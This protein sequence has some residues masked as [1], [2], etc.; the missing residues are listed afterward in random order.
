FSRIWGTIPLADNWR[1]SNKSS[2]IAH[3]LKAVANVEEREDTVEKADD[4]KSTDEA[5]KIFSQLP[6]TESDRAKALAQIEDAYFNLG[7]LY[8][9]KLNEK[10]N[11]NNSYTTLLNRFPESEFEPEVLYKLYLINTEL[12]NGKA[13]NYYDRLI[14]SHPNSSFAKLLL[15]PDYLKETS[16]AAEKQKEIY[17]D[18]YKDFENGRSQDAQEKLN[19]AFALG[20]TSFTPQ[21][22]LL[23]ILITGKTEDITR[24]QAELETFLEKNP[25]GPLNTYAK[26]L[27]TTSKGLQEKFE[28]SRNIRYVNALE[29]AHYFVVSH[30][31]L[32]KMSDLL[33]TTLDEFIRKDR[34]WNA[35]KTSTLIL[36]EKYIL[37]MVGEFPDPLS[38][39][40]FFD[41]FHNQTL[42]DNTLSSYKFNIFVV[43]KENS[44]ILYRT[45]ALDE[46][47]TFFDRNYK[48]KNQ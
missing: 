34:K 39:V 18:A 7:D 10:L 25:D 40:E 43:T 1:R 33:S 36:N 6:L 2:V 3:N 46:Y 17:Q 42:V 5:G 45:K 22:E 11:A 37:T 47:L 35:L 31:Q 26:S 21:L 38:A 41:K 15:N 44:D 20:E 30:L 8:Y 29:G 32:S 16:V 48:V 13:Q 23:R 24:Y 27:L 12:E 19:Q 28:K 4:E 9:F 14:E